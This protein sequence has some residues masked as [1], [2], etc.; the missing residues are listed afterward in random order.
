MDMITCLLSDQSNAMCIIGELPAMP[1]SLFVCMK[2]RQVSWRHSSSFAQGLCLDLGKRWE[3]LSWNG[4][5]LWLA[6]VCTREAVSED[7]Q[8]SKRRIPLN[9]GK[10]I[11]CSIARP[12][13]VIPI[14]NQAP[15]SWHC[16]V[17]LQERRGD[18]VELGKAYCA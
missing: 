7:D 10:K 6:L 9:Q 17:G 8:P 11:S 4:A 2:T 1:V 13:H 18:L 15:L 14:S 16:C 12:R 3:T 5:E